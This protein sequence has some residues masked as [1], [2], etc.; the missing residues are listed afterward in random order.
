[1][2]EVLTFT[3]MAIILQYINVLNQHVVHLNLQN[4][5][6]QIYKKEHHHLS[7]DFSGQELKATFKF[8]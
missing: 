7:L 5:L 6:C 3:P 8:K 2:I 4:V 1:M